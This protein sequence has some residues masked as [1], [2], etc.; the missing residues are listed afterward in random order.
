MIKIER[1]QTAPASLADRKSYKGSDVLEQLEND[2]HGKCYLCERNVG[3]DF[4][5]E[6]LR[7]KSG[8]PE[9]KYEWSNLFPACGCNQRRLK[10]KGRS[11]LN[12]DGEETGFPLGGMLDPAQDEIEQL[13]YQAARLGTSVID[14]FVDFSPVD[15]NNK[16]AANTAEELSWIHNGSG[17]GH[18]KRLREEL[19]NH[20]AYVY[21]LVGLYLDALKNGD[22]VLRTT[23]KRELRPWL[24]PNAPFA[25]V[26][27]GTLRK[28]YSDSPSSLEAFG[29]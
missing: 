20:L 18:F 13:L 11:E 5:V 14:T 8:Y 24:L 7:P 27:R 10:W 16:A 9:K 2:F 22:D 28:D 21:R 1:A 29:L 23:R 15:P 19:R 3:A 26:V 17:T 4:Q 25:G 12:A 6:H